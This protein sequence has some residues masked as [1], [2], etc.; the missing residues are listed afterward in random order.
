ML[1][2]DTLAEKRAQSVSENADRWRR[3]LWSPAFQ[4]V[5]RNMSDG[6]VQI[7]IDA[8]ASAAQLEKVILYLESRADQPA[9]APYS[10]LL[11]EA[12]KASLKLSD[13]IKTLSTVLG[14]FP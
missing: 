14:P 7:L 9:F 6:E 12:Q 3:M 10:I 1:D 13:W 11:Q 5:S 2:L 8:C 4:T